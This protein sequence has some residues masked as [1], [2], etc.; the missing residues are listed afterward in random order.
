[1]TRFCSLLQYFS[2]VSTALLM[3]LTLAM[4]LSQAQA[5]PGKD[6]I[7]VMRSSDERIKAV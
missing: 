2:T 4:G 1:M 7:I 5:K 6:D 3:A